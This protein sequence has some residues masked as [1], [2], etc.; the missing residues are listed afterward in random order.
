MKRKSGDLVDEASE[1]KIA[2]VEP[3][4]FDYNQVNFKKF[5][6]KNGGED[7]SVDPN[8]VEKENGKKGA[9]KKKQQF[10]KRGNK[11]HTFKKS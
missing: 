9:G 7:K 11:S 8:A 4:Q 6:S 5:G 10:H 1:Q 3:K 2:K